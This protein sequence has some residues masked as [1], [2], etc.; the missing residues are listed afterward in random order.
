MIGNDFQEYLTYEK[1][2]SRNTVEAYL[3]D[4]AQFSSY[5]NDLEVEHY[6]F[7]TTQ[8]VRLW[9][10]SL[11]DQGLSA[12]SLHRKMSSVSTFYKYSLKK[13]K[14]KSNPVK[15][16]QLPK[17]PQRLPKFIEQK[18]IQELMENLEESNKSFISLRDRLVFELFYATGIRRQELITLKW[19]DLNLS[20]QQLRIFGK[21]GKERL[22]PVSQAIINLLQEYRQVCQDTWEAFDSKGG[23]ILTNKGKQA[24]PG[25]IYRIVNNGLQS[26]SVKT[27][28]S[29]HVLR[30][31]F[32]THLLNE[33]APLN[34]IKE[35]LG[36]ASLA[37][38]QIYTHNSI[39]KLKQVFKRS[40][41]KA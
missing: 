41:P 15:G 11:V 16:I 35:L 2:F 7:V 28:K 9:M 3:N 34:D 37:S 17:L 4:L 19:V 27:Q 24:Y 20:S 14:V 38:T 31:T 5:L 22:V 29:P 26:V 12:S 32:A 30:H 6:S 10:V 25:L 23:V 18:F 40:H 1:R 36:H 8:T 33:G 13:G 39:E 21:G